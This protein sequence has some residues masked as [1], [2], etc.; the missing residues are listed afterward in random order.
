[1]YIQ[2][3]QHYILFLS[4]I[5]V[6]T[7]ITLCYMFCVMYSLHVV[8]KTYCNCVSGRVPRRGNDERIR[9]ALY[10]NYTGIV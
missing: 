1:M 5:S 8:N 2:H 4:F 3:V 7:T 6:T 9:R 10:P